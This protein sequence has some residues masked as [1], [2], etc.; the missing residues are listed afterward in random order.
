M[1]EPEH[2]YFTHGYPVPTHDHAALLASTPRASAC[3]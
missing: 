1:I 2:I 3:R